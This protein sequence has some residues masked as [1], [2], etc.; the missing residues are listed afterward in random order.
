MIT[1]ASEFGDV[2]QHRLID[3]HKSQAWLIEEVRKKTGLYFDSGY[4]HKIATGKIS[5]PSIVNAICEILEIEV[6]K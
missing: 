2:I 1:Q 3:I 6:T 4:F 5:T